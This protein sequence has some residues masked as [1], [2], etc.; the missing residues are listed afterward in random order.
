MDAQAILSRDE[1]VSGA[2]RHFEAAER[3]R[4]LHV[5]R[6]VASF[7]ARQGEFYA[8][9]MKSLE[10]FSQ[11]VMRCRLTYYSTRVIFDSLLRDRSAL[12]YVIICFEFLVML[13]L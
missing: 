7:A 10:S 1:A 9:Q 13:P 6:A 3:E 12:P 5:A 4:A 8:S 2:A 11:V